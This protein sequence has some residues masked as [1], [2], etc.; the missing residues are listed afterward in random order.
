MR[1][2]RS[3]LTS[4][5]DQP[6]WEGSPHGSRISI[7]F[8]SYIK[9]SS[10]PPFIQPINRQ[11]SLYDQWIPS[12]S[13]LVLDILVRDRLRSHFLP[14]RGRSQVCGVV[15]GEDCEV[16]CLMFLFI[17]GGERRSHRG[18]RARAR[19]RKRDGEG[20]KEGRWPF[21]GKEGEPGLDSRRRERTCSQGGVRRDNPRG[22]QGSAEAKGREEERAQQFLRWKMDWRFA[23]GR[24]SLRSFVSKVLALER[25]LRHV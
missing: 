6:I 1:E 25:L 16:Y 3:E 20:R 18:L 2:E 8:H 12:D 10:S 11:S 24:R 7:C 17:R 14:S 9:S 19:E 21:G 4:P 5:Q 15:L 22:G 23:A 13:S